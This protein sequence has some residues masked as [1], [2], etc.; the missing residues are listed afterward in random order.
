MIFLKIL[1]GPTTKQSA[2]H[3]IAKNKAG[4]Q[5]IHSYQSSEVKKAEK[6]IRDSVVGQL[7]EDFIP[8]DGC[9]SVEVKLVFQPPKYMLKKKKYRE[10]LEAGGEI[11]KP[12]RPDLPDNL[13]KGLFDAMNKVVFSDDARIV[14]LSDSKKV[15]GMKP[16]TEVL[17]TTIDEFVPIN[18]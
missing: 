15:Y 12:T 4:K 2:R 8:L 1:G 7:P 5:F 16:R 9:L 11:Y 13:L 18:E 10:H 14:R 17:I 6:N 3:R